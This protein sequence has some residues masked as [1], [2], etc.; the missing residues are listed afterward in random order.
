MK[1]ALRVLVI[2]AFSIAIIAG[3][4]DCEV[5]NHGVTASAGTGGTIVPLGYIEVSRGSSL[6]FTITPNT[7]YEILDVKVN[8]QSKGAISTYTFSSIIGIQAISATFTPLRYGVLAWIDAEFSARENVGTMSVTVSRSDGSV[9]SV[10]VSYATSEGTAKSPEDFTDTSGTL[11]W[12]DGDSGMKTIIVPLA[13]DSVAESDETF[14]ITLTDPTGGVE[15]GTPS[16]STI[17]ILN[18]DT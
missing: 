18:D 11:T 16:S 3:C 14:T 17:T 8:D 4:D 9:G 12:G 10:G 1:S 2:V 13:D 5:E 6:S 7:G 15:L